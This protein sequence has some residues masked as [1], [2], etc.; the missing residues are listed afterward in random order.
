MNLQIPV[1]WIFWL[2]FRRFNGKSKEFVKKKRIQKINL[3]QECNIT[4]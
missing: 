1:E 3:E 4:L 2:I